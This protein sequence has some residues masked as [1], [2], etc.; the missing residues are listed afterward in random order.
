MSEVSYEPLVR[1]M[2]WSY[3]RIK[4][5]D[6]C[7]YRWYLKYICKKKGK[8]MFFSDYGSFIHELIADFYAGKKSA[9]QVRS[10]YVKDFKS[11]VKGRAPNPKIFKTYFTNGLDYFKELK[12]P[13]HKVLSVENK[14]EFLVNGYKFV[15]FIDREEED[16][17]GLRITDN[18]SRTLKPRSKRAKPTK[19]DQ[20]LDKYLVQL[21]LY[22]IPFKE[23][24]GEYPKHLCFDCFREKLLIKEPFDKDA[25][26][27]AVQWATDSIEEIAKE[28]EFRPNVDFFKCNYLCEMNDKCEYY[29][30]SKGKR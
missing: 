19:A 11:K 2:T 14:V 8:P 29:A 15:G 5:F 27:A 7:P 1:D 10:E 9:A 28:T 16:E 6:D 12:P 23:R 21:Y 25:F 20:E 30:L 4:A 22:S 3:S 13:K 18:K 26:D 24:Y 17:D